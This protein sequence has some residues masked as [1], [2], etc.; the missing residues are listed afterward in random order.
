MWNKKDLEAKLKYLN[1]LSRNTKDEN[2]K[3]YIFKDREILIGMIELLKGRNLTIYNNPMLYKQK[4]SLNKERKNYKDI[5]VITFDSIKEDLRFCFS[6]CKNIVLHST[7]IINN[8]NRKI[9]KDEQE[10]INDVI[11]FTEKL[12]DEE[13]KK[14][15]FSI[16]E[17]KDHILFNDYFEEMKLGQTYN[18]ST[19]RESYIA[20][21]YSMPELLLHEIIHAI[22]MKRNGHF[23]NCYPLSQEVPSYAMQICYSIKENN[24]NALSGIV[25]ISLAAILCSHNLDIRNFSLAQIKK[26]EFDNISNKGIDVMNYLL[27][28]KNYLIALI[29]ANKILDNEEEG[30]KEYKEILDTRFPKGAMPDYSR[31]GI[32]NNDIIDCSKNL[33]KYFSRYQK[34]RGGKSK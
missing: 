26:L 30:L 32:T 31:W 19:F 9:A 4:L 12:S 7:N 15:I 2:I 6:L 22:D 5:E 8:G 24:I 11:S 18:L 20:S 21:C 25:N 3:Y 17:K 13:L 23:M 16:L 29:I 27:V 1:E 10:C 33:D 14:E 28:V 34:E